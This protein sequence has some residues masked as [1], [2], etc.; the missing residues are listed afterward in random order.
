MPSGPGEPHRALPHISVDEL[1]EGLP[2]PPAADFG[3]P[4]MD[5]QPRE[6]LLA[7]A[8]TVDRVGLLEAIDDEHERDLAVS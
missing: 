1:C 3:V 7:T 6:A 8:Q 2:A 5:P 4:H